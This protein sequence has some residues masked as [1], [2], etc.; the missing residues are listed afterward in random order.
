MVSINEINKDFKNL[1]LQEQFTQIMPNS[2]LI[3]LKAMHSILHKKHV[4]MHYYS[5]IA[6]TCILTIIQS[7]GG[8]DLKVPPLRFFAV[9]HLI[10]ELQY[11]A[12][13]T[14]PKK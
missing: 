7:G 5:Q 10:L 8:G 4:N 2:F 9:T 3:V 12:L 13:G 6:Y 14:F 1:P 11:C